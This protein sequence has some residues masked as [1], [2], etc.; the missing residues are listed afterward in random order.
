MKSTRFNLR[1]LGHSWHSWHSWHAGTCRGGRDTTTCGYC[2][3]HV[4]SSVFILL[5]YFIIQYQVYFYIVFEN[6]S[7]GIL[8]QLREKLLECYITWILYAGSWIMLHMVYHVEFAPPQHSTSCLKYHKPQWTS[9]QNHSQHYIT[10]STA[11]HLTAQPQP[12]H[13]TE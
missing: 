3:W 5:Y 2:L 7:I 12:C 8:Y 4:D 11:H 9:L 1:P 10:T 6:I 13:R